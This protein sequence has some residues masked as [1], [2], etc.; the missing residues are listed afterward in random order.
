[1]LKKDSKKKWGVFYFRP[2]KNSFANIILLIFLKKD[3][4][5]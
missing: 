4:F 2:K 5:F 1:M 3:S